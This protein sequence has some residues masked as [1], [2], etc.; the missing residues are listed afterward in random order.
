MRLSVLAP[1]ALAA[2]AMLAA[3]LGVSHSVSW[4]VAWTSAALAAVAGTLLARGRALG[5]NRGRWNLWA[6]AAGCW[7]FGQVAWD[8]YSVV[9]APASPNLSDAGW[10]GFAVLIMLSL[11]R[12]PGGS[13]WLRALATIEDARNALFLDGE[14]MYYVELP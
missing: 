12:I 9:G 7:L 2:A 8:V 10:W 4:D 14:V 6:L 13:S 3:R 1:L 11:V 5:P